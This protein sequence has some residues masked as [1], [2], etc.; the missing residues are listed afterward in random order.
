MD[1]IN[2]REVLGTLAAGVIPSIPINLEEKKKDEN[3]LYVYC[4]YHGDTECATII[5]KDIEDAM[6]KYKEYC[7]TGNRKSE[8]YKWVMR[9]E[10]QD[11][12]YVV[13]L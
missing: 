5:A 12:S 8:H 11:N 1:L 10:R 3:K 7:T 13:V 2:R 6:R 9:I 4:F